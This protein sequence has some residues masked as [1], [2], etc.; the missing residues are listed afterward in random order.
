MEQY[1][2]CGVQRGKNPTR[3]WTLKK[4]TPFT[5]FWV[6]EFSGEVPPVN[7][8]YFLLISNDVNTILNLIKSVS[9]DAMLVLRM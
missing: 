3:T 9:S 2:V 4:Y 5:I 6:S 1:Y 8:I 7:V